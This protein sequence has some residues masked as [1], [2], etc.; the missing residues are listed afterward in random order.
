VLFRHEARTGLGALEEALA[1]EARKYGAAGG[2]PQV[3]WSNGVL[4][5]LAVG[6]VVQIVAPWTRRPKAGAYLC[7][8]GNSGIVTE[9]ERF[10]RWS[11]TPCTHYP[12]AAVGD[13]SFDIR[14][15]IS[16]DTKTKQALPR[17]LSWISGLTRRWTSRS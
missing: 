12:Q 11:G 15:L 14:T 10:R 13:M 7:Y 17:W 16:S 1:E 2:R 5:S 4:A 6:L 9:A 3:V 8:D